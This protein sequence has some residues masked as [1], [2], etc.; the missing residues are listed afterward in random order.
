MQI[1]SLSRAHSASVGEA[2]RT[3]SDASKFQFT[4]ATTTPD[5]PRSVATTP[6][7]NFKAMET[8]A[9][10]LSGR[11]LD[12]SSFA[13]VCKGPA[14]IDCGEENEGDGGRRDPRCEISINIIMEERTG[15]CPCLLAGQGSRVSPQP[16]SDLL[17]TTD[18]YANKGNAARIIY[19][20]VR[21]RRFLYKM[22]RNIVGTL[23]DV[24]L[25][26]IEAADI[27]NIIGAKD[28]GVAGTGAPAQGLCLM[29]VTYE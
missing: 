26:R 4:E 24:G 7:L 17:R 16:S 8:A 25:G 6:G 21:G 23:M 19:I 3:T 15:P 27:P 20:D 29:E 28:R 14:G 11:P 9:A 18:D 5:F 12:F 10:L 22:V 13:N 2:S 1:T